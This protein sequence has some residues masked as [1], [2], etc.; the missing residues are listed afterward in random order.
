MP[1][2]LPLEH[3]LFGRLRA[4]AKDDWRA[5]THHP[6]VEALQ[7]GSLAR[8]KFQNFLIQDYLF[9]IQYARAYAL[10]AYK[11][12]NPR[13][14]RAALDT[15]MLLLDGEMA[16]HVK[17]CAG[18]GITEPDMAGAAESLEVLAYTR[19][20]LECGQAGDVLDLMVALAPCII[21]YAEI[22]TRLAAKP[23][24][25]NPYQDW[26]DT[27]NGPEYLAS[28]RG[29]IMALDDLGGRRGA[30][31]R[32]PALLKTFTTAT[33]LEAAFWQTGWHFVQTT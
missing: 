32:Y 8:E 28:V 24:P 29:A 25:D 19:F 16:L 13:D 11:H 21:G 30:E 10:A 20:V 22:G 18:W 3:G 27:Y 1:Q 4:D 33:R 26:I 9:L 14:M 23:V 7:D 15:A 2:S 12:D 5:Y 6:F 17:Y 31:A